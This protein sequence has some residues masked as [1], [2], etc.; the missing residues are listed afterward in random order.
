[1]C[2]RYQTL[3]NRKTISSIPSILTLN[4]SGPQNLNY[5]EFRR[6]WGTPGWLPEEIGIIVDP[7]GQFF[8]YEGEDLKLH[9]QRGRHEIKVYSLIGM[10]VNVDNGGQPQ[11][12]HLVAMVNGMCFFVFLFFGGGGAVAT[13]VVSS[14]LTIILQWPILRQRPMSSPSGTCSMTFWSAQRL[15]EKLCLSTQTGRRH[16]SSSSS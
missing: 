8:C 10:A 4:A 11:K 16:L 5:P 13:F 7:V 14:L 9:L 12:P 6:L 1:M 15:P 2:Q 3:L